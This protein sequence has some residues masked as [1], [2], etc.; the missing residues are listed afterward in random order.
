[1]VSRKLSRV[2]FSPIFFCKSYENSWA[3]YGS[4][5]APTDVCCLLITAF[6]I[7]HLFWERWWLPQINRTLIL[8]NNVD[9]TFIYYVLCVQSVHNLAKVYE[10]QCVY[11]LIVQASCSKSPFDPPRAMQRYYAGQMK[12]G[13]SGHHY[14]NVSGNTKEP[15]PLP[16]CIIR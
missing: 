11:V 16:K 6:T 7:L 15:P 2:N 3:G 8:R 12:Q 5:C 9:S 13:A 4:H 10:T 14:P 1:M